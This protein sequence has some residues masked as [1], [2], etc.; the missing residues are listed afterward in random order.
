MRRAHRQEAKFLVPY[1]FAPVVV[2]MVLHR[3]ELQPFLQKRDEGA[4]GHVLAQ[5]RGHHGPGARVGRGGPARRVTESGERVRRGM[6]GGQ[7]PGSFAKEGPRGRRTNV[8]RSGRQGPSN[9][10]L[11]DKLRKCVRT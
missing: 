6:G 5:L 10:R 7:R 8:V 9:A 3:H 1:A 4:R 11:K 2:Q